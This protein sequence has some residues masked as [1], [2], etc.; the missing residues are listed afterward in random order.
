MIETKPEGIEQ[1]KLERAIDAD[2]EAYIQLV[3]K[4]EGR[5]YIGV[6][7]LEGVLEELAKG[8]VYMV[9]CGNRTCGMISYFDEPGGIHIGELIVDPNDQGR[10]LGRFALESIL[11]QEAKAPRV[12]LVTHP[13]NI[14]AIRLYESLGFR[15]TG[16]PKANY[17]K[18]GEPRVTLVL[19]RE[20]AQD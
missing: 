2:A 3:R 18:D 12:R 16:P 10:G 9:R 20:K 5:T 7:T 14:Q 8:Y 6:G 11:K 15:K 13:E 19:E 17:F 4:V 1:P